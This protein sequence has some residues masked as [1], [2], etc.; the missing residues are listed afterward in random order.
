MMKALREAGVL[1]CSCGCREGVRLCPKMEDAAGPPQAWPSPSRP[2]PSPSQRHTEPPR[3]L[4]SLPPTCTPHGLRGVRSL[5]L[6]GAS[7]VTPRKPM[8]SLPAPPPRQ[9]PFQSVPWAGLHGLSE[10]ATVERHGPSHTQRG[11]LL[12]P[13]EEDSGPP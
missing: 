4:I 12:H 10:W 13:A 1:S 2:S 9:S 7:G 5:Q 11:R 6:Q 8:P 3:P